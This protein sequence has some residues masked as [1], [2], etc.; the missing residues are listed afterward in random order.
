VTAASTSLGRRSSS[1]RIRSCPSSAP[2]PSTCTIDAQSL[3]DALD[4]FPAAVEK[5]LAELMDQ[6]CELQHKEASRIVSPAEVGAMPGLNDKLK[7]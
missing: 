6:A 1:V 2:F 5:A 7:R 3:E 4:K